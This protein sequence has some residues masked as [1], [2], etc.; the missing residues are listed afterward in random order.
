MSASYQSTGGPLGGAADRPTGAPGIQPQ[1]PADGTGVRYGTRWTG[2]SM[3]DTRQVVRSW[4]A[5]DM[6]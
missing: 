4:A 5:A 2:L 6:L 3:I 1:P